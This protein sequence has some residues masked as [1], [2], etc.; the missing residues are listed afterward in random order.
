[1]RAS[2]YD[3]ARVDK[4]DSLIEKGIF[5]KESEIMNM[6]EIANKALP[7]FCNPRCLKRILDGDGTDSSIC[8]KPNNLKLSPDNEKHCFIPLPTNFTM[9]CKN[10]LFQIG[11]KENTLV[12]EYGFESSL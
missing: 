5:K 7:Y 12:N 8:R 4:I 9:E 2:I 1:M 11:L 3:I 10:R 6:Q